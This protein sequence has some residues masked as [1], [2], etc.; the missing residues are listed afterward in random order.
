MSKESNFYKSS[1]GWTSTKR[2][3]RERRQRRIKKAADKGSW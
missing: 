2:K 3:R 1:P